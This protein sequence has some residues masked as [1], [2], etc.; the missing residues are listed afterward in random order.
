MNSLSLIESVKFFGK[1]LGT[2]V[3]IKAFM[4]LREGA[5]TRIPKIN[6]QI[7]VIILSG[8]GKT[9]ANG[10]PMY[11]S[12]TFVGANLA[13]EPRS[14]PTQLPITMVVSARVSVCKGGVGYTTH[15]A[16][17]I[18][19]MN[20]GELGAVSTHISVGMSNIGMTIMSNMAVRHRPAITS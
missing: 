8:P 3:C 14:A 13:H 6:R 5:S 10:V 17:G 19:T 11:G 15:I 18:A 7:M 9:I 16:S 12:G 4:K 2:T 20:I 1:T